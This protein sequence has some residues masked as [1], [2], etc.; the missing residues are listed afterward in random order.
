M[1]TKTEFETLRNEK[2][3][4]ITELKGFQ[5]YNTPSHGFLVVPVTNLYYN[6]ARKIQKA[7]GY[8]YKGW[9]AVYLEEDCQAS[10]FLKRLPQGQAIQAVL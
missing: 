5:K 2:I 7:D 10:A 9:L 6:L 1:N 4:Y 8:G 3:E